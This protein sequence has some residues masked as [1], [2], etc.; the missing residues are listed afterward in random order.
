MRGMRSVDATQS[1][2]QVG[3]TRHANYRLATDDIRPYIS[4]DRLRVSQNDAM[5]SATMN[6]SLRGAAFVVL[7]LA[8][9]CG[10]STDAANASGGTTFIGAAIG[11][12]GPAGGGGA[13]AGGGGSVT[14]VQVEN[15]GD[16][17]KNAGN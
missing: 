8:A 3:H 11:G 4:S 12:G 13:G 15:S 16:R 17:K 9:A 5:E 2:K 14:P 7:S 6:L 10:D 1:S